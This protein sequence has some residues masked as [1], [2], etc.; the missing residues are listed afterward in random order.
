MI[1]LINLI[2]AVFRNILINIYIHPAASIFIIIKIIIKNN[3]PDV[4][5]GDIFIIIII[6]NY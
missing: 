6:T 4:I 2:P 3:R 5:S 1:I